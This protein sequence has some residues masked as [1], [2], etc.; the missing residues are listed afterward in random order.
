[1]ALVE[2][3]FFSQHLPATYFRRNMAEWGVQLTKIFS[4]LRQNSEKSGY[5]PITIH[6]SL[7]TRPPN[8]LQLPSPVSRWIS[9]YCWGWF[10]LCDWPSRGQLPPTYSNSGRIFWTL[11]L[12]YSSQRK[13]HLASGNPDSWITTSP[14]S[15]SRTDF[16]LISDELCTNAKAQ[17][18]RRT[19]KPDHGCPE[20]TAGTVTVSTECGHWHIPLWILPS[21]KRP[22]KQILDSFSAQRKPQQTT[23]LQTYSKK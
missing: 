3:P 5:L 20:E 19:A 2:C 9:I 6:T 12:L 8:L 14:S 16:I 13:R 18:N 7:Q 11:I 1:M 4:R 23:T 17:I 21:I 10:Q 22:L 15:S